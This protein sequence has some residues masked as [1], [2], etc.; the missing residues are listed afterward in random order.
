MTNPNTND[1]NAFDTIS[2]LLASPMP[3]R[4]ALKLV[5]GILAGAA[6]SRLLSPARSQGTSKVLGE[7]PPVLKVPVID[8]NISNMSVNN[9]L[10]IVR[11]LY[12]VPISFIE[13][14]QTKKISVKLP[15][16]TV[17]DILNQMVKHDPAYRW[18]E[19]RGHVI[20]YSS[21]FPVDK[22]SNGG[23]SGSLM[24]RDTACLFYTRYLRSQVKGFENLYF[25]EIGELNSPAF[26]NLVSASGRG[27][28]LSNFVEL[29]DNQ[30]GLDFSILKETSQGYSFG[31]NTLQGILTPHGIVL[32][33][34]TMAPSS[35]LS[36]GSPPV[37]Q[38]KVASQGVA[39]PQAKVS[40]KLKLAP[41]DASSSVCRVYSMPYT[42]SGSNPCP[43]NQCGVVTVCTVSLGVCPGD[44][45]DGGTFY[46]KVS[47][48]GTCSNRQPIAGCTAQSPCTIGTGN[49]TSGA[50]DTYSICQDKGRPDDC[51]Y[52]VTQT[53]YLNDQPIE[54]N[55]ITLNL[56]GGCN[57]GGSFTQST[58]GGIVEQCCGTGAPGSP[59][60]L[61]QHISQVCI[62]NDVCC[63][64]DKTNA[65]NHICCPQPGAIC[66]TDSV[67][68]ASI[69][70]P[71]GT[72]IGCNGYCC[73]S[74]QTC[75]ANACCPSGKATSDNKT[76]CSSTQTVCGTTCCDNATQVCCP[77]NICCGK[78][79]PQTRMSAAA[80]LQGRYATDDL[81]QCCPSGNAPCGTV[82]CDTGQFCDNG[83]CVAAIDEG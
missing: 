19:I 42:C 2:R 75:I 79:Q 51:S 20:L 73:T 66:V 24:R 31:L 35:R 1:D 70:C 44:V 39:I 11:E 45:C 14:S 38:T 23:G 81:S 22:P 59:K 41:Y 25:S 37:P 76:C 40:A 58:T 55:T 83:E 16:G 61:C 32:P 68:E 28:I 65:C 36:P 33:Q 63:R 48:S 12:Q 21:V 5:A 69:C 6:G 4:Q 47:G 64:S 3:R 9:L 34:G 71:A 52:T 67:T 74:G 50:V 80:V 8:F 54:I 17:E 30:K 57:A 13:A 27:S 62:N 46:E 82:C 77:G 29:L 49:S 56:N 18:K 72:T 7:A 10:Q 78:P 26:S 43:N 15:H 60:T 53:L